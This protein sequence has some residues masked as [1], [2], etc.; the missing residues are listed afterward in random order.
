MMVV[1]SKEGIRLL[2]ITAAS[3][4]TMSGEMSLFESENT[5]KEALYMAIDS[6]KNRFG[7]EVITKAKLLK[8]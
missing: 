5:K 6:L 7:E 4:F 2:G 8:Q 3:K 1:I